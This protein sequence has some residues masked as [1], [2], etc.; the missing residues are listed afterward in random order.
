MVL[1]GSILVA[2]GSTSLARANGQSVPLCSKQSYKSDYALQETGRSSSGISQ[3][4]VGRLVPSSLTDGQRRAHADLEPRAGFEP[5]TCRSLE[6]V[7]RRPL[8]GALIIGIYQAEPPRHPLLRKHCRVLK[9]ISRPVPSGQ[10]T[11]SSLP[12]VRFV[13]PSREVEIRRSPNNMA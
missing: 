6:R 7:T 13:S 12:T 4:D 1:I 2:H 3:W 11:N 5:A 10:I 9:Y 8:S